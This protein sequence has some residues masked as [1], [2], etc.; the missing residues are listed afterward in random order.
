MEKLL[1]VESKDFGSSPKS[2]PYL[3]TSAFFTVNNDLLRADH[4][5]DSAWALEKGP[6]PL[7]LMS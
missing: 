2:F 3:A 6:A 5:P 1:G 7:S 4:A